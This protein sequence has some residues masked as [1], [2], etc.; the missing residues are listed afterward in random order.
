[1]HYINVHFL[2]H[3]IVD[4]IGILLPSASNHLSCHD[5]QDQPCHPRTD[6]PVSQYGWGTSLLSDIGFHV[7]LLPWNEL[8]SGGIELKW[9]K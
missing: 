5:R 2:F 6:G 3:L 1:M 7:A 9:W 8:V 4:I